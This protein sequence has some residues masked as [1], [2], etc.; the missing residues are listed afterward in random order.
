MTEKNSTYNIVASMN[1]ATV[2]SEYEPEVKSDQAYQSEAE[3]EA[4]FI[5]QLTRHDAVIQ[6]ITIH[7][8]IACP[9]PPA[10][11]PKTTKTK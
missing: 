8:A 9:L 10:D 5:K 2:A 4:D 3:L 1:G 7:D 6:S 11:E